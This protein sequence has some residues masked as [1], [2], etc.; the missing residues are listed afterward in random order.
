LG[1]KTGSSFLSY[2]LGKMLKG[3]IFSK[4]GKNKITTKLVEKTGTAVVG[5][6][7]GRILSRFVPY[8]GWGLLVNDL[9]NV[10][11]DWF[12]KGKDILLDSPRGE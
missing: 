9:I 12:P 4:F 10:L 6:V 7:A 11:D 2:Y 5:R 3:N 1:S 8:V